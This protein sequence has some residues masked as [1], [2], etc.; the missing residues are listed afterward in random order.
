ML[1]FHRFEYC[2]LSIQRHPLAHRHRQLH[3]TSG[4]GRAHCDKAVIREVLNERSGAWAY[5]V[6]VWRC[7]LG[8]RAGANCCGGR[9]KFFQVR[10]REARV[11]PLVGELGSH[12]QCA[13]QQQIGGHAI[14]A[15]FFKRAPRTAHR[16]RK[17]RRARM[18]DELG[19]QGVVARRRRGAI[20]A[21]RIDANTGSRWQVEALQRSAGRPY[22]ALRV[23]R[24]GIDAPLHRKA[25]RTGR[26]L[27]VQAE[28]GKCLASC[29]A[30]LQLH[31]V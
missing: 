4:H 12:R 24:F 28:R 19:Q 23:Q 6:C 31:Q 25:P 5:R 26:I 17:G 1:H 13:Q 20:E 21:M 18:D 2:D 27:R 7:W 14:D 22:V 3:Q 15:A 11:D 9:Q 16:I 10:F 29:N 8:S 30:D